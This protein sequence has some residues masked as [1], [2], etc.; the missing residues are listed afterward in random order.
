MAVRR[1]LRDLS[2]QMAT[3][4]PQ[5]IVAILF[6]TRRLSLQDC[7]TNFLNRQLV[8]RICWGNGVGKKFTVLPAAA[9]LSGQRQHAL[10]SALEIPIPNRRTTFSISSRIRCAKPKALS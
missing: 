9:E 4:P 5:N 3:N 1:F 7:A 10:S 8:R 6:R 2:A